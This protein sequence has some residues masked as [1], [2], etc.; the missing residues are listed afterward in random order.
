[1]GD[2]AFAGYEG[3][4]RVLWVDDEKMIRN[5]G[6]KLLK[7]LNHSVDVAANGEEALNLLQNN[8]YDL[9]ITDIGMPNMSGWQLAER[10]KGNYPEMKVAV[11]TGWGADVSNEEKEKYG[12][13]YVLAKPIRMVQL[14][15]LVGEVLQFKQK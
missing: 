15:H 10:I 8:Q 7:I 4:I 2:A 6:K 5:V 11:V 13:G 9:M 14:K 12:L 3:S 1:M